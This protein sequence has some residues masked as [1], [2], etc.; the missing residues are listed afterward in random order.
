[1]R[2]TKKRVIILLTAI[3]VL[4]LIWFC[5]LRPKTESQSPKQEAGVSFSN[6]H[7]VGNESGVKQWELVSKSLK[8]DGDKFHLDDLEYL[9]LLEN[10]KPKYFVEAQKGLWD[11][12]AQVL[13]LDNDVV[14]DDHKGFRLL[15]NSLL[16]YTEEDVFY[17]HGDTIVTFEEGGVANE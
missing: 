11:R 12:K 4:L 8:Q 15:T 9:L 17:F 16:W 14:V 13:T 10:S 6:V 2:L 5:N 7:L 3:L 1:M